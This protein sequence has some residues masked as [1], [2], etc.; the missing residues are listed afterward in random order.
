MINTEN[1]CMGCM[2]DKGD[3]EVCPVCGY[4]TSLKNHAQALPVR[5][6]LS[7][8]F[9]VGKT[10]AVNGEG[11]TYLGWDNAT[12]S[13]VNVKEYFPL[14]IAARNPDATVSMV[15]DKK[16]VFNEGLLEFLE[17]NRIVKSKQLPALQKVEAVFEA[18]GTAYAVYQSI[19]GITLEDFLE[20]NGGTLK[21]EQA[22]ALLLPLLDAVKAMNDEGII[23][24][25]ISTQKII[26]GRDGK[27]RI[28]DY[29]INKLRLSDVDVQAELYDGYAA[30]EQYGATGAKASP[31]TDVYG[32]AAMLFRVLIGSVIPKATARLDDASLS[33]PSRFAEELPRQVFT[34]LANGLKVMPNE[35]T[36]N[37]EIFKNE[38]VYG[39]IA[40]SPKAAVVTHE[41]ISSVSADKKPKK[42]KS[43]GKYVLISAGITIGVFL[44]VGLVLY[45]TLFKGSSKDEK[46]ASSDETIVI[47]AP[48][49]EDP[50]EKY[51]DVPVKTYTVPDLT[52]MTY[53]EVTTSEDLKPFTIVLK[54]GQYSSKVPKGQV[55]AQS[56]KK[57]K[58]VEWKTEIEIMLSLGPENIKVPNVVGLDELNA[59]IELMKAGFL[60]EN[61]VVLEKYDE[62][63]EPGTVVSQTPSFGE[64]T[65][66][67]VT[68]K[69][70]INSYEG[71]EKKEPETSSKQETGNNSNNS[72]TKTEDEKTTES[73]PV[74]SSQ[75]TTSSGDEEE[76]SA[77]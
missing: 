15:D 70:Y 35:R 27:L 55:C 49:E 18:N 58:E 41:D 75:P 30:I 20:R 68:V 54:G 36:P 59:K 45:F 2:N 53:K 46:A 28:T 52:G 4:N 48:E 5:F 57:G 26:V 62:D 9:I 74:I 3:A 56:V 71:E 7:N 1:L 6:V 61:I 63:S 47:E 66:G 24:K 40:E 73:A 23:H 10:L 11:I 51:E 8:R 38:L 25:G 19:Q 77:P 13:V 39:E 32:F 76:I 50:T 17:V 42:S 29:A 44:L 67:F 33:I 72:S 43:G 64:E 37:I 60:Y 14:G 34:A 16:Y 31:A 65:N 21:W 22:R 69:I 12:D